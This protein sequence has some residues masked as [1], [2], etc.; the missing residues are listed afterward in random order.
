M[1]KKCGVFIQVL[2]MLTVAGIL[3]AC[4]SSTLVEPKVNKSIQDTPAGN[5]YFKNSLKLIEMIEKRTDKLLPLAVDMPPVKHGEW[6]DYWHE[7]EQSPQKY[8]LSMPS[9][10]TEKLNT[11]YIKPI[12]KFSEQDMIIL[13]KIV[14]FSRANFQT[15]VVLLENTG[16]IFPEKAVR[17]NSGE[18][19]RSVQYI[20][21]MFC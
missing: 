15:R 2:L 19:G 11:L 5:K 21:P 6:R 7:E 4:D 3:F 18:T 12:G 17:K 14:E 13:Q 20:L 10:V 16:D 1:N 8:L 9:L